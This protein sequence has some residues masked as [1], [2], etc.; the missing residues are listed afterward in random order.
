MT[1]LGTSFDTLSAL[2]AF[3]IGI[4][5]MI[6]ILGRRYLNG[7]FNRNGYV[8]PEPEIDM[9]LFEA[10]MQMEASVLEYRLAN[11]RRLEMAARFQ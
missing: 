9:D 4:G 2:V 3:N 5:W 1:I 6:F 7:E 11:Q 8:E 10:E